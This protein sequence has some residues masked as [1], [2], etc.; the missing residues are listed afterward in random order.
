MNA[1]AV[2]GFAGYLVV[3]FAALLGWSWWERKRRETRKPFPEYLKLLRMPGEYLQRRILQHD[4]NDLQW[5]M[6]LAAIP[7]LIGGA[8]LS[9][10]HYVGEARDR[11]DSAAA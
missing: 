9:V 11:S 8:V 7:I 5:F 2:V 10:V 1:G 4:E 6:A 3:F